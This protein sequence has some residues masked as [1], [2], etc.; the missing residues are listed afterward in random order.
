MLSACA[1]CAE[2]LDNLLA[3]ALIPPQREIL[4]HYQQNQLL[5]I[6]MAHPRKRIEKNL[7]ASNQ[8]W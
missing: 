6:D 2:E 5:A 7:T 3:E 8:A 4:L 1:R